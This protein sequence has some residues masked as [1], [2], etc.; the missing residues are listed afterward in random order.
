M[1]TTPQELAPATTRIHWPESQLAIDEGPGPSVRRIAQHQLARIDA[2]LTNI[3]DPDEGIHEARKAMK[4]LRAVIRL[5]RDAAGRAAYREE[6]VVLRDTARRLAPARDGYVLV[7]TLEMLRGQY[8]G[9]LAPDAF[10][11]T[12]DWLS[13]RHRSARTRVVGDR[14]LMADTLVTVRTARRRF[15]NWVPS[16]RGP[17]PLAA[18]PVPV[19]YAPIGKG[20]ARTYRRGRVAMQHA[21]DTGAAPA[22]HQW[23]KRVKYLRYQLE[24]LTPLYPELIAAQ[25]AELDRLGQLLGVE[26]DLAVLDGVVTTHHDAT[27]DDRERT[28]LIV[29]IRR[30]RYEL[31]WEARP[32]GVAMYRETPAAFARRIEGYW[33]AAAP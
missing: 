25:A 1:S 32:I 17:G 14:Q 12:H 18:R 8:A 26:H 22:F 16:E 20:L 11:S 6:N 10:A 28:M 24:T 4:R 23:R 9:L 31:Q 21:Y 7:E 30:A 19:G 29:L 3:E 13:D 15:A 27:A 33:D 2:A 5:V